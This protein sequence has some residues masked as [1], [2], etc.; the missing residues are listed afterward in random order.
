M[1]SNCYTCPI[2]FQ[3]SKKTFKLSISTG[4]FRGTLSI[5][6]RQWENCSKKTIY[7]LNIS[8]WTLNNIDIKENVMQIKDELKIITCI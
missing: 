4:I 7:K 5:L 8:K 6:K 3:I 2:F 1:S